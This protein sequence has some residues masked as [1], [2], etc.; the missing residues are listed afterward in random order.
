M[1]TNRLFE[2]IYILLGQKRVTAR[3]LAERFEVSPRTIY[4]DIDTLSLAGIPVYTEKGKGGGIGLLP[5]FVLSKSLL[6]EGEQN[7]ILTALQS[8]G[9]IKAAETDQVLRKLSAVFNKSA[10]PWLEVD[11]SDWGGCQGDIFQGCKTAIMEK[12]VTRFDYYSTYG[13]KTSRRAEPMQLWFKS[14]AWYLRAFC[15]DKQ[16]MRTFKLTRMHHF[17]LTDTRFT[18]RDL[19]AGPSEV[20]PFHSMKF[21]EL[22]L[23][24]APEMAHRMYDEFHHTQIEPQADGSFLASAAWLEDDW[25]YNTILSYGEHI[26]V[27]EPAYIR[28]IVKEKAQKII[29][30]HS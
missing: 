15:L 14:K 17:A 8:L 4:R 6:S 27:L 30:K 5:D 26:E 16:D 20:P 21:V 11:F 2:I 9:S 18:E 28:E 22:T 29:K 12:R 19:P 1:Q 13:E 25:V 24:I 3:A 23:K 7:E 10:V